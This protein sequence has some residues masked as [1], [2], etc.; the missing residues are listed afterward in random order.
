MSLENPWTPLFKHC[1][2]HLKILVAA[3]ISWAVFTLL[4]R[5]VF[6]WDNFTTNYYWP[7]NS[8]SEPLPVGEPD[9]RSKWQSTT[10]YSLVQR[11]KN[12]PRRRLTTVGDSGGRA[13]W[14]RS[15]QLHC[16]EHTWEYLLLSSHQHQWYG[17]H[18]R[19]W[20]LLILKGAS[21]PFTGI[22]QFLCIY[23]ITTDSPAFSGGLD[24]F[25]EEVCVHW[26]FCIA[27]NACS[28]TCVVI[29]TYS[30]LASCTVKPA[31]NRHCSDS[32]W[33]IHSCTVLNCT[34][35]RQHHYVSRSTILCDM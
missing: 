5:C 19:I 29:Y 8:H 20:Q 10:Q 13:F 26:S 7:T 1:S 22:L 15:V 33:W 35:A 6:H 24:G 25:L 16:N 2:L 32:P 31:S 17:T 30:I 14:R 11:W 4:H 23:S 3:E 18:R 12:H 27:P 9:M 34:A 21:V 28:Y